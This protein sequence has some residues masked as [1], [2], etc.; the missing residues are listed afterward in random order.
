MLEWWLDW[1]RHHSNSY[2]RKENIK[3]THEHFCCK[4]SLQ[5]AHFLNHETPKLKEDISLHP[6]YK[7]SQRKNELGTKSKEDVEGFLNVL[8]EVCEFSFTGC[9]WHSYLEIFSSSFSL[10]CHTTTN[11]H[12]VGLTWYFSH[13]LT[14]SSRVILE[15]FINK[16]FA[17]VKI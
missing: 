12:L 16:H 9:F 11:P 13:S 8:S 4:E 14:H 2:K 1:A 6:K 3:R 5:N 10:P 15:Q 17:K 7:S